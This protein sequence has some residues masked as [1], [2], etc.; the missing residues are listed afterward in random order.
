MAAGRLL[1]VAPPEVLWHRP[2]GREVAEFLGYRTFLAAAGWGS[3]APAPDGPLL[4]GSLAVAPGGWRVL[5]PGEAPAAGTPVR[6]ARVTGRRSR[7]GRVEVVAVIE[8]EGVAVAATPAHG[9]VPADGAHVR[10]AADAGSVA[11]LGG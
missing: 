7:R 10:V 3:A 6:D 4:A 2:A 1:Q 8:P 9:G 11:V 5:A